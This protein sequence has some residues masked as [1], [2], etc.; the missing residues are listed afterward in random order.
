MQLQWNVTC[1]MILALAVSVEVGASPIVLNPSFEAVQIGS[2]YFSTNVADVPSWTRTGVP[3]D[4]ALWAVGY[5]DSGGSI[6]T[7][8]DG[9]QFTTMG[10][11]ATGCVGTTSWSQVIGGFTPGSQYLL[12]F[13]IA[14]EHGTVLPQFAISQTVVVDFATGSSTASQ[15]FTAPAPPGANYWRVWLPQ[16]MLFTATASTV[17]L[18]FSSTTAYDVGL[19]NVAI[20]E[21]P[22]PTTTLLVA[23]GLLAGYR[24]LRK[25]RTP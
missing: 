13:M 9:N 15:S 3:G 1:S 25:R 24:R 22:E 14:N 16:S 6:T 5:S 11:G 19:D 4:A 2:P 20:T 8:G 21:V 17:T 7:A 12:T 10:C 18:Q 23:T